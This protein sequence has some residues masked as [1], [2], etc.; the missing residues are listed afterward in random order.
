MCVDVVIVNWN[1]GQQ[2]VE[3]VTSLKE[4]AGAREVNIIVVDNGSTD[5]S[6]REVEGAG[7]TLIRTGEN[8]GF[9]R[10]CNLGAAQG[11]AE[12]ILFLNPDAALY[13]GTL[14]YVIDYMSSAQHK[15]VGVCSVQL[16]DEHG[17]IARS[18]TR[19]PTTTS[20]LLHSLGVDRFMP[21]LGFFMAE[22][23][24]SD[25]RS[26]D[27]VIGAFYFVRRK[28]FAELN[29]FDERFFVYLEDLDLSKRIKAK[30]WR[31]EFLTAF[32][33]FHKGG[34]TSDQVKARRL[35]YALRSRILYAYKHL[36]LLSATLISL[37]TLCLEP[38]LR[39]FLSIAKRSGSGV[40]ET[41]SAYG[42]LIKWFA[43]WLVT[44]RTR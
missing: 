41:M 38:W 17:H 33:A 10:A 5:G 24:H 22:W 14:D 43:E 7:V 16:Q 36:G 39:V 30:G 6:D 40:R 32:K 13:P 28:V 20:L 9:G 37:S 26:V 1:A 8:L 2:L 21:R 23:D 19:F 31:I 42:M 12:F 3:C 25:D 18:C 44:G 27:H 34:G 29:G 4:H 11:N 15:G 35:F